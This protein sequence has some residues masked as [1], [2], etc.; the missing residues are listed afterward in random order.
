[1][2]HD[3]LFK[4]LLRVFFPEFLELFFPETAAAL[5][6][7]TLVFL[8]KE[9]FPDLTTGER[10]EADLI[11]RAEYRAE[12]SYFLIHLEHQARA[13]ADFPRRMF[14]YFARLHEK[15]GLPVY[16]IVLFSHEKPRRPE[17][18]EYRL[19]FP[20]LDV[21]TFRFRAVQLNRLAWRDF[22]RS[23]NPVAAALLA[24]MQRAVTEK[25]LVL[26]HALELLTELQLRPAHD[27]LVTEFLRAY[28]PLTPQEKAAFKQE[29][30][31]L[32]PRKREVIMGKALSLQDWGR[33]E[34][35]QDIVRRLLYKRLGGLD[36]P[37]EAR[38]M[39]LSLARLEKLSE[40]LLD[41]TGPADLE[42][43]LKAHSRK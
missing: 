9:I 21:L 20:D 11:V 19:S 38:V 14:A 31:R 6:R 23:K 13:E 1:M 40:A 39:A 5:D 41:F 8:D 17:P 32:P 25:P 43:W 12:R 27:R 28:L 26:R 36:A 35:A 24:H 15:Y 33:L 2:D 18:E 22:S 16:P 4:E 37:A 42:A 10:R 3:R 7:T 30:T 34:E 29:V